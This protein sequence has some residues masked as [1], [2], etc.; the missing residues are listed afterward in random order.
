MNETLPTPFFFGPCLPC[1]RLLND[2][3]PRTRQLLREVLY[4]RQGRK[5]LDIERLMRFAEGLSAYTTDALTNKEVHACLCACLC[6]LA[7]GVQ[8][9]CVYE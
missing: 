6:A 3:S 8:K 1:R 9:G 7:M 2:D 5:R 4:G